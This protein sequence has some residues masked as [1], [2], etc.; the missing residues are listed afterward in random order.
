M[1]RK[2]MFLIIVINFL[3]FINVSNVSAITCADIDQKISDYNS[4]VTELSKLD[5][6]KDTD[7]S[8]V[9]SCNKLNLL[10]SQQISE[11]YRYKENY[12]SCTSQ[13]TQI[14]KIINDNKDNC[15]LVSD[16]FI[17]KTTSYFMGIFYILGP[18][19]VI[20]FG[21]IDYTKAIVINDPEALKKAT[22]NFSKRLISVIL[23]FLAPSIVNLIINFN[24][25][26]NI[27][28]GDSYVCGANHINLKKTYTIEYVE[29]E[30]TTSSGKGGKKGSSSTSG[31]IAGEFD[32]YMI[33]T[34]KP[35]MKDKAYYNPALANTG[36][37]VWYVRGRAIEILNTVNISAAQRKKAVNKINEPAGE[38]AYMFWT[39]PIYKSVFGSSNDVN[40]PKEG[41]IIVFN[42]AGTHK[43]G[44]VAMVE[45]VYTDEKTGK[46]TAVDYTE[47]WTNSGSCPNSN[48]S[49]FTFNYNSKVPLKQIK[50][51]QMGEPF[52]GYIYLLN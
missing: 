33:R 22:R 36:Q 49:C 52:M 10:K 38:A 20:I 27:L 34:K 9:N 30:E 13:N 17:E 25:S 37:C 45:K 44:H 41:A 32:G 15:S 29:R 11:L 21:T 4:T 51:N 40:K 48:M 24:T 47:G 1:K 2:S 14:E 8:I 28:R 42:R 6:T 5:C 7:S 18:I 26:D 35:T 31:M 43:Y 19:L 3:F 39:N 12:T 46:A 16:G 50:K 23:L